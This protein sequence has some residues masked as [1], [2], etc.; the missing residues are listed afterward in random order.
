MQAAWSRDELQ[1]IVATIAFGMG[2]RAGE[3]VTLQH[4]VWQGLRAD[5]DT[6]PPGQLGKGISWHAGKAGFL[7]P[8]HL[9]LDPTCL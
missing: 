7:K 5:Q 6:A 1:V 9:A 3:P 8:A 4:G 2:A